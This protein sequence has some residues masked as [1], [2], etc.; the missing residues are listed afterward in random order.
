MNQQSSSSLSFDQFQ[1]II[2]CIYDAALDPDQWK[3]V[4]KKM[5][6]A[7]QAEQGYMRI[8]NTQSSHV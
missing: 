4:I 6:F 5:S 1:E 2:S 7:F 8:I 3:N